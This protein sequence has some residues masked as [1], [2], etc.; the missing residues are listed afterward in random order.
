MKNFTYL[1]KTHDFYGDLQRYRNEI[2]KEDYEREQV[3]PKALIPYIY[4]QKAR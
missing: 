2:V 4:K 3:E 1:D